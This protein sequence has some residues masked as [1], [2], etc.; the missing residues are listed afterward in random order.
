MTYAQRLNVIHKSFNYDF[1]L[2]DA[3]L[4]KVKVT[5]VQY[6]RKGGIQHLYPQHHLSLARP[7]PE[8]AAR[9]SYTIPAIFGV[10]YC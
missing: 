4:E 1:L 8:W 5:D 7:T 10:C 6:R 3:P 2:P 9:W